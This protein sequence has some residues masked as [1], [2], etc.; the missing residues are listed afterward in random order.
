[1]LIEEM[2]IWD[3]IHFLLAIQTETIK[4]GL[5]FLDK[6]MIFLSDA[7]FHFLDHV[8]LFLNMISRVD[9]LATSE[10]NEMVM[11]GFGHRPLNS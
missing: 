11:V 2:N 8:D 4:C 1:M 7:F 5:M 10:A 6:K 3:L 9:N